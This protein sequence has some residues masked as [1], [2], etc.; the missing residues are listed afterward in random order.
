[1]R[2]RFTPSS[3]INRKSS[4]TR[5]TGGKKSPSAFGVNGPY[6]TPFRKNFRVPSKKNFAR[7]RI[8]SS[9]FVVADGVSRAADISGK[10]IRRLRRL[11]QIVRENSSQPF[12]LPRDT[13]R[14]V[15]DAQ[16]RRKHVECVGFDFPMRRTA[17]GDFCKKIAREK[18]SCRFEHA[19]F[20]T[21]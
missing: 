7:T 16:L 17:I 21:K 10:R 15:A 18:R 19:I 1:M 9:V 6:V 2:T 14:D 8:G 4:R 20:F 11:T 12:E 13:F 3:P 5:S